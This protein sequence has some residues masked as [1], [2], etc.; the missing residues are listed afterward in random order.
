MKPKKIKKI[1]YKLKL[2]TGALVV[3]AVGLLVLVLITYSSGPTKILDKRIV[4]FVDNLFS[5]LPLVPKTSRQILVRASI[6]NKKLSS[7]K[8]ESDFKLGNQKVN[9]VDIKTTGSIRNP[10]EENSQSSTKSVGKVLV[11]T[12]EDFDFETYNS[13][14]S[15]FFKINNGVNL[16][17]FDTTAIKGWYELDLTKTAKDLKVDVRT[18]KEIV[19]DISK[20]LESYLIQEISENEITKKEVNLEGKSYYQLETVLANNP[21]AQTF[22]PNAKEAESKLL[23]LIEKNSF[24]ISKLQLIPTKNEEVTLKLTYKITSQNE[25]FSI[26][27]PVNP[28]KLNNP[29][30]AYLLLNK[31]ADPT[32]ES[33]FKAIGGEAKETVTTL[34]TIERLT[35]VIIL[36]PKA[37]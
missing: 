36:L 18:E 21:L 34:L 9:I 14:H 13:G 16:P 26:E 23:I 10:G 29:I 27:K 35:K 8:I 12:P 1:S 25:N 28:K 17:E 30:E 22:L 15:L 4:Y 19:Q 31:G 6:V 3:L 37:I 7:Y 32:A 33:L 5:Q 24:F 11:P 20:Q 2:V